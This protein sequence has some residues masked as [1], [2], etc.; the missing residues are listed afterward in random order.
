MLIIGHRGAAGLAPENSL[1]ALQAGLDAGADMLEFDIRLTLD[2]IPILSH[3]ARLNGRSV[4]G[5][6]LKQ[7]QQAGKVTTLTALLDRFYGNI[8]LNLEYKPV[9]GIE[10]V[11]EQLK[12]YVKKDKDWQNV[13]ISSFHVR[14]LSKLRHLN[15]HVRLALLHSINPFSFVTY[16]RKLQLSAVGWHRLHVN[17]LAIAIAHKTDLF[18]YV[19]TVNRPQAAHILEQKGI[20]GVVT[21]YPDQIV[22]EIQN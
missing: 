22:S 17:S 4:R 2:S 18:C 6:T 21:D 7:L 12:K 20:D 14:T 5:S 11:Y 3:D 10:V 15:D 1:E 8:M 19:Y 16:Q 9:S 13:L